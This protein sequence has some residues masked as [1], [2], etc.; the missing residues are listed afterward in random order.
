MASTEL[1]FEHLVTLIKHGD[2]QQLSLAL[3]QPSTALHTENVLIDAQTGVRVQELNLKR[4]LEAAARSGQEDMVETLLQFGQ[5]HNV[6]VSEMISMDTIGAALNER[7]LEVLLKYRAVDSEVFSRP[8]HLGA[9]LFGIACSGGP[10]HEDIPRRKYLGLLQHLLEAG[11][12]PNQKTHRQRPGHLLRMACFHASCDIVECLLRHGAEIKG[13]GAMCEASYYGRI[14]VLEVLLK[15]GGDMN[16]VYEME[17]VV[18]PP[19]TALDVATAKGQKD[20]ERWL[21]D[22]GAKRM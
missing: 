12:D 5:Q 22:H 17:D 13:S 8:L 7:P 14:D 20:V 9:E 6:P 19:G 15:Y 4:L 16:E 11:A 18:G 21:L 3:Q 10:N 2:R 1:S